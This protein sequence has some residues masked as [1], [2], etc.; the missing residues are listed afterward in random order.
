MMKSAVNKFLEEE[1]DLIFTEEFE[2]LSAREKSVL[3]VI[4]KKDVHHLSEIAKELNEN[5]NV[6]G[7]YIE[8]LLNKGIVVKESRGIYYITDPIFCKWLNLKETYWG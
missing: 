4:V 1:G 2:N 8:Y 3:L 5:M 6:V 7:R